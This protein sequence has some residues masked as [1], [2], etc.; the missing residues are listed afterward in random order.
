MN[1][2]FAGGCACGAVRYECDV[3]PVMAFNCHCRD[4][5]RFS[6]TA[7]ASGL[8]VPRT[9]LR[10]T[11]DEPKYYAAT[12]D[13]GNAIARGF[14]PTCGSPVVA[15]QAAFPVYVIYAASLDDPSGH[16]PTMDIFAA[17]AQPWDHM[18]PDLPKFPRGLD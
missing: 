3:A 14:C 5:Q 15:T 9:G 6:G 11:S 10:F 16:V 1:V 2:P 18:N 12:A 13:S 7:Y 4:C 8:I 17:S